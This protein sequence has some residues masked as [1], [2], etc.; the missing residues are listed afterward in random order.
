ML[1]DVPLAPCPRIAAQTPSRQGSRS[2]GRSGTSVMVRSG[3]GR[4]VARGPSSAPDRTEGSLP[5]RPAARRSARPTSPP[6]LH[7]ARRGAARR[8]RRAAS[9]AV[10]G[11]PSARTRADSA[12]ADRRRP[13]R[14]APRRRRPTPPAAGPTVL[15]ATVTFYGR[16][17]GHGVGMSQYG[18]R[19]RALAGQDVD[20]R[21]SPT[22]TVARRSG[23]SP[24]DPRSGS[25]SCTHGRRR[26]TA[27]LARLRPAHGRGPS[28]ASPRSFPVDAA[29]RV[30]PRTTTTATGPHTTWRL[31]VTAAGRHGPARRAEAGQRRRLRGADRD[32]PP[33]ALVEARHVRP[34]PRHPADPGVLDGADRDR[35]QRAA[36]RDVPA[37]RRPGR[38]A[39]DLADRG[40]RRPRRS[41]PLVRGPPAPAGR[42]VLRR[43][44]R[45]RARRS[46][47]ARWAS[48]RPRTRSSRPRAGVVLR[49]GSSIANT[50][51]HSTG[52]GA[53][54]NNENVYVS[55]TGAKV[56]GA[57]SYLRGSTD[58]RA[59]RDGLRRRRRRTRPG[60]RGPTRARSCRPGSPPTRGPTVGTLQRA[61]PAR[62]RRVGPADQRHADRLGRDEDG[63]GRRLP[64]GLQRRPPGRRPD[65]PEHAVRDRA[66]PLSR[67]IV[68]A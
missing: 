18:A 32:D 35:R 6:I 58:R 43:R 10:R 37:R 19:G 64:V 62:P 13:T 16:G 24:D 41:P 11:R 40:A 38:D 67:A 30:I 20:R 4:V 14:D 2:V 31:R 23:R 56:A 36:A 57:V 50:L 22:T 42:L 49:S 25:G 5:L 44:R 52:G 54:E 15:G 26:P 63:L 65:A 7:R 47:A 51:F 1:A 68:A 46:T 8:A 28:T 55:S 29:L 12:V 17:Y 33:P 48:R 45:P 53:T 3:H 61:R 60:R 27:P 34:V 66:D 21:S 59:G 9:P 39:V